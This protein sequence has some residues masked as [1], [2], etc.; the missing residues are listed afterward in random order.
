MSSGAGPSRATSGA[1]PPGS[2]GDLL[3]DSL[4]SLCSALSSTELENSSQSQGV[5]G[6]GK[7][8]D[9]VH[10]ALTLQLQLID[11]D[12][13]NS[14]ASTESDYSFAV[15]CQRSLVGAA[16]GQTSDAV[17][18]RSVDSALEK[19]SHILLTA[20]KEEE[21]ARSDRIMAQSLSGHAPA[22][23]TDC[24]EHSPRSQSK[25]YVCFE[26]CFASLE[27]RC[28]HKLCRACLYKLF[29]MAMSDEELLPVR[30]FKTPTEPAA[31]NTVLNL[32]QLKVLK[33]KM[34][35][36]GATN[37]LYCPEPNCSKFMGRKTEA[38]ERSSLECSDCRM[39]LY[40]ACGSKE[41]S[42]NCQPDPESECE[43][44]GWA[45]ESGSQ[46]KQCQKCGRAIEL[47][48]G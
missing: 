36:V 25:C 19:D 48:A 5:Q 20:L 47:I 4:R 29:S 38:H 1:D 40:N 6:Y 34:E 16:I 15:E 37:P 44:L 18:P 8:V 39:L 28:K 3:L 7:D 45:K 35:E 21:Q 46:A 11:E 26:N 13:K 10:V 31:A 23:S 12:T 32:A 41:H 22:S 17:L 27:T 9:D 33:E 24:G 30:Y 14:K 43:V 2:S 42:R